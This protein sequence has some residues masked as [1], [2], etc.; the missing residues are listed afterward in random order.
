MQLTGHVQPLIHMC[1][2]PVSPLTFLLPPA[3]FSLGGGGE[4]VRGRLPR[5][6]LAY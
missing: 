4:A 2:E 1:S 3:F 5:F 6:L